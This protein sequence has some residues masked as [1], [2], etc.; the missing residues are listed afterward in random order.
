MI[1]QIPR[2]LN[3]MLQ[4]LKFGAPQRSPLGFGN[5]V[6]GNARTQ[7]PPPIAARCIQVLMHYIQEQQKKPPV[8]SFTCQ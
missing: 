3:P 1:P 6:D 4:G 8:S 7:M 5:G 2:L